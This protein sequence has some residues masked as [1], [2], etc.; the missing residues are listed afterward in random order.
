ML[1]ITCPSCHTELSTQVAECP[2]C[3]AHLPEWFWAGRAT[4]PPLPVASGSEQ[5]ADRASS[6]GR[7]PRW[8]MILGV[9]LA[10]LLAVIAALLLTRQNSQG[11]AGT[12]SVGSQYSGFA[13][14]GQPGVGADY[15]VLQV[16]SAVNTT[17]L[18]VELL[19]GS[20]AAGWVTISSNQVAVLPSDNEF[21]IPIYIVAAGQ[22]QV[23]FLQGST[24]LGSA[25]FQIP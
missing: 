15:V 6:G 3:G 12:V 19:R 25:T 20:N 13:V 9:G 16:P 21:R 1:G 22:Y 10:T 8:A 4:P 7:F 11:S 14:S 17:S 5:L 18:T 23:V 2:S 24:T